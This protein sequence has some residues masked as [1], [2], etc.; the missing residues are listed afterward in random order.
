MWGAHEDG[1]LV[2]RH[3]TPRLVQHP[4]CDLD[5]L[6]CLPGSG[7]QLHVTCV[8]RRRRKLGREDPRSKLPECAFVRL[9]DSLDVS[10]KLPFEEL[11]SGDVA[12]RDHDERFGRRTREGR[13]E[14]DFTL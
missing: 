5:R 10:A 2:E 4:A 9:L 13:G 12:G 11:A 7:K 8:G 6:A 1:H 3:A 14:P